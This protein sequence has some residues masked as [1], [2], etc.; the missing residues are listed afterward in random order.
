MT[1]SV[2][3]CSRQKYAEDLRWC[4]SIHQTCRSSNSLS[5]SVPVQ[6]QLCC[7]GQFV[8][9]ILSGPRDRSYLYAV[10]TLRSCTI[11]LVPQSV[12][13]SSRVG[14]PRLSLVFVNHSK[15]HWTQC[16]FSIALGQDLRYVCRSYLVTQAG[17]GDL[18][19]SRNALSCLVV[20]D[21][22]WRLQPD[23]SLAED[24][25][26]IFWQVRFRMSPHVGC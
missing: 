21:S 5:C 11:Q 8:A 10:V 4:A 18:S 19:V 17:A 6:L 2:S 1:V 14:I 26:P 13:C 22:G 24:I 16:K 12:S 3:V 7:L 20:P 15:S 23:M 25:C 9:S